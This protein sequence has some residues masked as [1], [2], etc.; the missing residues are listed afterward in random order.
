MLNTVREFDLKFK[1]KPKNQ[2]V[3][4]TVDQM[5]GAEKSPAQQIEFDIIEG[6]RVQSSVDLLE[7]LGSNKGLYFNANLADK[8]RSHIGVVE[9]EIICIDGYLRKGEDIQDT[10]NLDDQQHERAIGMLASILR[11]SPKKEG[12]INVIEYD[13]AL[14]LDKEFEPSPVPTKG[15]KEVALTHIG[16][17]QSLL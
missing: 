6:T 3:I 11:D 16:S 14:Q 2:I 12:H 5:E 15:R 8:E 10:P 4:L 13:F 9:D 17:G 7:V 1:G